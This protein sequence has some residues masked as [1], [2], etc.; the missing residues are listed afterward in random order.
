MNLSYLN[1]NL[2]IQGTKNVTPPTPPPTI[3]IFLKIFLF[4]FSLIIILLISCKTAPNIVE[5]SELKRNR[6]ERRQRQFDRTVEREAWASQTD[7]TAPELPIS[8]IFYI[9]GHLMDSR[10]GYMAT[11]H[12]KEL[13]SKITSFDMSEY[14]VNSPIFYT[15]KVSF[16]LWEGKK[17]IMKI[18]TVLTHQGARAIPDTHATPSS[19][20]ERLIILSHNDPRYL[21][22]ALRGYY[23]IWDHV[24]AAELEILLSNE[25][26]LRSDASYITQQFNWKDDSEST[27]TTSDS[28][29]LFEGEPIYGKGI[30]SIRETTS[31]FWIDLPQTST[32]ISTI[33]IRPARRVPYFQLTDLR[34]SP[35]SEF[36]NKAMTEARMI[37]EGKMSMK[38]LT[39]PHD[40]PT[41]P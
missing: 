27:R 23:P 16:S 12:Y 41:E 25:D 32:Q 35:L 29:Y 3:I 6:Y 1:Y 24:K 38:V 18:K 13:I 19:D 31:Y 28:I 20:V 26:Q 15:L 9:R 21:N 11:P 34:G 2:L 4:L 37:H 14:Q 39:S 7:K 36:L 22:P 30:K 10:G 33:K 17:N 5:S 8:S 40:I